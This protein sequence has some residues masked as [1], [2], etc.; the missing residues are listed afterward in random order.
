MIDKLH[1]ISQAQPDGDHL[2][3]IKCALEAGCKWIQ[4]RIKDQ[5][6]EV[7]L[8]YARAANSLCKH[9]GAKL[10]VNDYPGIALKAGAYGL[11]LGLQ[12]MRIQDARKIVGHTMIIGGTANTIE[13]VEQRIAE[14]ADYVGLGPYRFTTTKKNLSPILGYE[15]IKNIMQQLSKPGVPVIAIGGIRPEDILMIMQTG[16]HGVALSGAITQATNQEA[17]VSRLYKDLE[18]A[19]TK[20]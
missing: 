1:Y 18:G 20:T 4:L 11:H 17:L 12:D 8:E 13:D 16:V 14:G 7:V 10:I 19:T 15:G 9:H 6:E 3:S 2:T 5:S